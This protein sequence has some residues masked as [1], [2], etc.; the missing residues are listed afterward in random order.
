M[1]VVYA[2]IVGKFW[3]HYYKFPMYEPKKFTTDYKNIRQFIH[4]SYSFLWHFEHTK[5]V[6]SI[7]FQYKKY[8]NISIFRCYRIDHKKTWY[9]KKCKRAEAKSVAIRYLLWNFER[10]RRYLSIDDIIS[11]PQYTVWMTMK[12]LV[13]AQIQY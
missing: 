3:V 6:H 13:Y 8:S 2:S 11:R 4:L 5:F 1:A 7:R 12:H 9:S 10:K